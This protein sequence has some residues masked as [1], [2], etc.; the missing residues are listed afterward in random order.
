MVFIFISPQV[1]Y[2]ENQSTYGAYTLY[3]VALHAEQ[4]QE[5]IKAIREGKH[6]CS[7]VMGV[8]ETT[9]LYTIKPL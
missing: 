7:S 2:I 8:T 6:L 3:I 9:Y 5:W 1:V 4:R